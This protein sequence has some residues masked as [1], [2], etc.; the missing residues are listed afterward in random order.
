MFEFRLEATCK[1]TGARAGELVTPH[2]IVKTPVFMPVGTLGTVK[3]MSSR[4]LHEIETQI[5]LG[6]TYH[7]YLRPGPDIIAEA[8][9]LHKFMNW[10]SPILTDSGGFQV[11]SLSRL[12]KITDAGVECRSHIDGSKHFMSPDWAM[13][14]QRKLGSDIMMCFDQ[15]TPYPCT[16]NEAE[17]ALRRTTLWA[18]RCHEIYNQFPSLEGKQTTGEEMS[19]VGRLVFSSAAQSAGVVPAPTADDEK[20]LQNA[21]HVVNG[22]LTQQALFGIIQGSVFDD[23]RVRSAKEITSLDFTGYAIGGLSVGEPHSDMYRI[24][25][26]LNPILPVDKP[27]YLM[28]VGFPTNL[29]EGIAR[30]IDMFDCVLPTRNGRNGTLIT[31]TGQV[32]I[33]AKKYERDFSP[34]DSECDCTLCR[35]HTRAYLRH[36][37]RSGEILA[38]RLCSEH[39]LRFLIRIAQ[40]AREAILN[41]NYPAYCEKFY[42]LFHDAR[43]G[44]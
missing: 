40:G 13:D 34:M 44:R 27:R 2:G 37:Y 30:G 25:D 15:C 6:N 29:I 1:T 38:A 8:G 33:K 19:R 12:N 5:I 17:A 32:N 41:G 11:F 26:I 20:T 35:L 10:H 36:L 21:N 18:E 4:E 39:N 3:A 14:V 42:S 16:R 9:G 7:L 22:E 31:S 43:E 28:G 24:L 23:L